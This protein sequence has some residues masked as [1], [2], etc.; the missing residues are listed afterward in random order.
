MD[1]DSYNPDDFEESAPTS[2]DAL[3]LMTDRLRILAAHKDEMWW[4]IGQFLDVI[5]QQG[6]ATPLGYDNFAAYA[7]AN[8]D[9]T[10]DEAVLFR[11]VAHHFAHETASRFGATK[12][13]LLLQYL[14]A[15]PKCQCTI[16]VLRVHI[17]VRDNNEEFPIPF[18]E[19]SEEDLIQAVRSAKRRRATTDPRIPKDVAAVRDRL[20]DVITK[21]VSGREVQVKVHQS[22]GADDDYSL[23]LS[24]L[25]PFNMRAVGELIT[26]E[27]AVLETLANLKSKP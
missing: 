1:D 10:K 3:S 17:V 2:K 5:A 11:R 21:K 18:T 8:I 12:L 9:I 13:D 23:C 4:E 16:D 7:H 6:L 20:S 14:E 22:V 26:E 25:D 15:M 24:G 27:G 19:I